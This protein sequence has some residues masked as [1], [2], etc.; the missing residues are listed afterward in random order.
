MEEQNM[1]K[2][3]LNCEF[4]FTQFEE[5]PCLSCS[6]SKGNIYWGKETNAAGA[7]N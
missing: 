6:P 4:Q 5:E 3:C 2:T 7:L 1:N